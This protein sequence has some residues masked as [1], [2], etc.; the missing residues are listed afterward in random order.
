MLKFQVIIPVV[1]PGL[2][3]V[4]IEETEKNT[5]LPERVIIIDNSYCDYKPYSDK[6]PIYIYHSISGTVNESINL[7]IS[8]T[9]DC[10]YVSI[11]NDDIQIAPWFFFRTHL[12]F[13]DIPICS[14]A[15]PNTIVDPKQLPLKESPSQFVQMKKRAGWCVSFRKEI[16]DKVPPIPDTRI[17]TFYGDDWLW[18]WTTVFIG[19]KWFMDMGNMIYHMIGQSTLKLG[20]RKSKERELLAWREIRKEYKM[21]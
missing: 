4:L 10:D 18:Y 1:N 7:G 15:C 21:P 19:K 13:K 20:K 6:F 17:R 16:L 2:A 8:K 12:I 11:F 3:D 14:V 5:L 9:H